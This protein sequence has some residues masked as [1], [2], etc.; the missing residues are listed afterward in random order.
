MAQIMEAGIR[1]LGRA[2]GFL[3]GIVVRDLADLV[4]PRPQE[5]IFAVTAFIEP[6]E[7]LFGRCVD[8][9]GFEPECFFLASLLSGGAQDSRLPI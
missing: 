5:E 7:R 2:T 8:R 1:D 3:E 6:V 4:A 9:D